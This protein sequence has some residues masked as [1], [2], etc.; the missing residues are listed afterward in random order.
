M[1][2]YYNMY[3]GNQPFNDT[4]H[5]NGP[6]PLDDRDVFSSV[7]GLYFTH[8]DKN[9][10]LFNRAYK[11]MQVVIFDGSA[12]IFCFQSFQLWTELFVPLLRQ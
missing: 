2:N 12:S 8:G 6:G 1:A 11:G 9:H 5:L 7:E 10:P 4:I 3:N